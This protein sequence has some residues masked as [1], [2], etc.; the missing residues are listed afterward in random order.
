[1]GAQTY[2]QAETL[3][4]PLTVLY[5][6]TQTYMQQNHSYKQ[7]FKK[8]IGAPIYSQLRHCKVCVFIP[9][10]ESLWLPL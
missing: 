4:W 9:I 1:M 6:G 7:I 5:T 3:F 8:G 2:M 10:L